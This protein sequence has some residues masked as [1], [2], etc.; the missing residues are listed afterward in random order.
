VL[1]VLITPSLACKNLRINQH[2]LQDWKKN[3]QK[4]LQM[5]KGVIKL[6]EQLYRKELSLKFKLYGALS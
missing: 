1:D 2:S 3:K 6:R 4:I 5:K